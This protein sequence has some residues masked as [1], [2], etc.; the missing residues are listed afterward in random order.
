MPQ[1]KKLFASIAALI[2]AAALFP[3]VAG[4]WLVNQANVAMAHA[5]ALP[6]DS[7]QRSISLN[8]AESDLTLAGFFSSGDR[9]LVAH[10]R[11]LLSQGDPAGAAQSFA[12]RS[13]RLQSDPIAR[14]LWAEAASESN[15][16]VIA[17]SHWRAAGAY[18]YYSQQMHRAMDSHA[19]QA[20]EE[21]RAHC[22]G[23]RTE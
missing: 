20:A 23:N 13:T 2:I 3:Q 15:Q 10:V 18:V 6:P 7:P 8:D 11:L 14:F 5:A 19:W 22:S 12:Q 21:V 9:S 1:G 16:P 17:I 4:A